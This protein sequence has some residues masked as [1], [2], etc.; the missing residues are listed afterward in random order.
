M[1]QTPIVWPRNTTKRGSR[2]GGLAFGTGPGVLGSRLQACKGSPPQ[3]RPDRNC[4][5]STRHSHAVRKSCRC[6][7]PTMLPTLIVVPRK[8]VRSKITK[9]GKS[10]D[11][12]SV[13]RAFTSG[14]LRRGPAILV[15]YGTSLPPVI[16]PGLL[17]LATAYRPVSRYPRAQRSRCRVHS[18]HSDGPA[19][20][21][22]KPLGVF[23]SLPGHE[24]SYFSSFPM[25]AVFCAHLLAA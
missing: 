10:T 20:S 9:P 24:R 17:Y 8:P 6:V 12:D 23:P 16:R 1:R 25:R 19:R 18:R 7:A 13:G 21:A 2:S 15:R 11:S 4:L 3:V 14:E 22:Q 5:M